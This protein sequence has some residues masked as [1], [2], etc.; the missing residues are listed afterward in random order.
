MN[1]NVGLK[2]KMIWYTKKRTKYNILSK[3]K[4]D[5][6][7]MEIK[8]NTLINTNFTIQNYT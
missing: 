4:N 7:N 3:L 2:V 8:H 6:A 5:Q 1:V